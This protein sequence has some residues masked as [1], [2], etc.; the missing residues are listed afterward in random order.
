MYSTEIHL[1]VHD[2]TVLGGGGGACFFLTWFCTA[3]FCVFH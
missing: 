2:T 1:E 3:Q